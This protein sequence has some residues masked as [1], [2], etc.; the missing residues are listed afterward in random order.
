MDKAASAPAQPT[1]RHQRSIRNYLLDPAFQLKYTGY[2]VAI[3]VILSGALGLL[4]WKTSDDV[5][6]QSRLSVQQGTETVRRGQELVKESQKLSSVERMQIQKEYADAPELA[7]SFNE[8]A[9]REQKRLE[10]EQK[11]LQA[12][13]ER[14]AV[15]AR[16]I[17]RHQSRIMTILLVALTGLVV[18]IGFAGIVITH[19][20]AGPIFK[21]KRQIRELGEGH[22][23]MPGKL[24]KGDE[25]VHFFETFEETVR[26]LRS[27]QSV[28]IE[29]L[30][31]AIA[32]V[33]KGGG[34]EQ[35]LRSLR[36]L[37]DDMQAELS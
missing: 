8:E 37:R 26:S 22:L 18:F 10:A 21:M 6:A 14:L 5:L 34:G 32:E 24:R 27:R 4:L 19:K 30:D 7:K 17:E 23:R 33:E 3:A 13:S 36:G 31:A 11:R 9:D 12:E 1:G 15:H 2:L 35:A 29:K 20:I 16:E 28:E 25:L